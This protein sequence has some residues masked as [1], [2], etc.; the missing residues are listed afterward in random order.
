MT[1]P[2]RFIP[3]SSFVEVTCRTIQGR[4]LL[5]PSSTMNDLLLGVLGRSLALYPEVRLHAFVFLSNHVHLLLSIPEAQALARFMNHLN[6]NLARE[7]GRLYDWKDKL[8]ARPYHAIV[9]ADVASQVGRLRYV[10]SHGVKERL[11]ARPADWPGASCLRALTE[12]A[13]LVG[14]WVDRARESAAGRRKKPTD[15]ATYTT[16]YPVPLAP[17]PCWEELSAERHQVHCRELVA[18]IEQDF[19]TAGTLNGPSILGP[20][21]VIAQDP[22]DRPRRSK[23]SPAPLV[24]A[25]TKAVRN[26]FRDAYR[27]FVEAFRYASAQLQRGNRMVEFPPVA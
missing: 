25:V 11:V 13:S 24:H 12:G 4:F 3:P 16:C 27:A 5:K 1:R 7:A 6:S 10:L 18:E 19:D 23:K 14:T 20:E 21:A 15:P 9:V 26:A 2:L 8:W 17:L 22:H